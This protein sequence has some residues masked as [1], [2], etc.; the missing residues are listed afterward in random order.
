[1]NFA[2]VDYDSVL[3]FVYAFDPILGICSK[4]LF[5][6]FKKVS[7]LLCKKVESFLLV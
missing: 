1:M 5:E 3:I 4:E 6:D 7:L 2:S